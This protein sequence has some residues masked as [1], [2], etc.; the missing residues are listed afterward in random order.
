MDYTNL[1]D[2]QLQALIERLKYP[3]NTISYHKI[4][5]IIASLFGTIDINEAIIDDDD[6]EYVLGIY[7]GKYNVQKFTIHLRFKETHDHLIRID[8]HPT[9]RH[10]NPDGTIITDSHIHIYSNQYKKHDAIAIPLDEFNFPNVRT[11]IEVYDEF[12]KMVNI[13]KTR[14]TD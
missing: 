8:V 4:D 3:K 14:G 1:D 12:V 5:K 13:K 6:I 11:I 10:L 2:K 7:R 9:G